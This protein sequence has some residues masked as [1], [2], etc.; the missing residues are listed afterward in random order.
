MQYKNYGRVPSIYLSLQ[1]L[2]V[3]SYLDVITP[4]TQ[5]L[6]LPICKCLTTSLPL[7]FQLEVTPFLS[8]RLRA[9]Q[10]AHE[11]QP[12]SLPCDHSYSLLVIFPHMG[13]I[14]SIESTNS[15][16]FDTNWLLPVWSPPSTSPIMLIYCL[17][18]KSPISLMLGLY[19]ISPKSHY[20]MFKVYLTVY[21]VTAFNWISNSVCQ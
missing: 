11:S 5:V 1:T 18:C 10:H 12:A 4:V 20:T 19:R 13:G 16:L 17:Q 7:F 9:L 2:K 3:Y 21:S 6:Y 15:L 14:Q 8:A